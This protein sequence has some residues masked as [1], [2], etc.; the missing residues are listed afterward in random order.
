MEN[1]FIYHIT[2]TNQETIIKQGYYD[3][4]SLVEEGF[5]HFS[6]SDQVHWV[7]KTFYTKMK[8]PTLL[9]VS[10]EKL[11]SELIYEKVE[12]ANQYFPHLF[13]KLNL[14]AIENYFTYDQNKTYPNN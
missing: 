9:Q 8:K 1:Q 5:I 14:E 3:H 7:Y 10:V 6:T 4:P 2:E 13:G 11:N 12:D